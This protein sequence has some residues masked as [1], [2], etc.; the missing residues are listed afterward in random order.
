MLVTFPLHRRAAA[1]GRQWCEHKNNHESKEAAMAEVRSITVL[2]IEEI[3]LHA[4]EQ[5]DSGEPCQH[6]YEPG[7]AQAWAWERAYTARRIELD[8]PAVV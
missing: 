6:G 5:A 3:R 7:S 4:R 2:T 8:T 1:S